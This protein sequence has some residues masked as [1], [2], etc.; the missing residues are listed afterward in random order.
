[1]KVEVE[2]KN[3]YTKKNT[4]KT[5]SFIDENDFNSWKEKNL[6]ADVQQQAIE[7]II[8]YVILK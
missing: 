5:L 1:M 7:R 3:W 2:F 4:I 6:S 8:G